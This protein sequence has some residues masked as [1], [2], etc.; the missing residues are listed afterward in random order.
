MK[1]HI[2][3]FFKIPEDFSILELAQRLRLL[4]A[5]MLE[6]A[7]LSSLE[8][9]KINAMIEYLSEIRAAEVPRRSRAELH[10]HLRSSPLISTLMLL[11]EPSADIYCDNEI[12]RR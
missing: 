2:Q 12:N 6:I 7:L 1:E 10:N 11:D 4:L 5:Y 9:A 3:E 8:R